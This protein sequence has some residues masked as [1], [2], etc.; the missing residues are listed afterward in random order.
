MD[1]FETINTDSAELAKRTRDAMQKTLTDAPEIVVPIGLDQGALKEAAK[2]AEEFAKKLQGVLDAADPDRAKI[3]Q[4][5]DQM[6]TLRQALSEGA[7]SSLEFA[8]ATRS[9]EESFIG[10]G[11]AA[12]ENLS[13]TGELLRAVTE[14]MDAWSRQASDNLVEM[15]TTGKNSFGDMAKSILQ[16]LAK[17]AVQLLVIKPLFDSIGGFL[18]PAAKGAV[19]DGGQLV[20]FALGGIV[21]T[22]MALGGALIGEAGPEAI[23]P[24]RRGADGRLG[25][26]GGGTTVNVINNSGANASV[27]ESADGSEITVMI[28]SA[29]ESAISRGRFDRS[30]NTSFGMRRRGA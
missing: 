10:A 2:E 7:I 4:F 28:E 26:S 9:L 1:L 23:M 14:N 25:V 17:M 29:L 5:N 8:Q 30:F 6:K 11:E 21:R 27:S 19:Y 13:G 15:A 12:E 24:L 22:P 3:R 20:P 18:S 16:D